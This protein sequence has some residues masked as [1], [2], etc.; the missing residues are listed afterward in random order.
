MSRIEQALE[1]ANKIRHSMKDRRRNKYV[2]KNYLFSKEQNI[3][4]NKTVL[5]GLILSAIVASSLLLF[6]I[7]N[8]FVLKT[9]TESPH[10]M[11]SST[12]IQKEELPQQIQPQASVLP[13]EAMSLSGVEDPGKEKK[14]ESSHLRKPSKAIFTIQVGAFR[15]AIYAKALAKRLAEKGYKAYIISLEEK[16]VRLFKVCVGNFSNRQEA[17]SSSD[18]IKKTEDLQTFITLH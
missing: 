1:K 14:G 15:N 16:H 7:I 17:E 12:P 18:K 4:S 13:K 5:I 11:K 9:P 8:F 6:S 10:N 2:R 3:M